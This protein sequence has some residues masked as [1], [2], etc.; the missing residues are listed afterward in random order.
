MIFGRRRLDQ[1][2]PFTRFQGCR[3][4]GLGRGNLLSGGIG[5]MVEHDVEV[6]GAIKLRANRMP[7]VI[8][9]VPDNAGFIDAN[10]RNSI[11]C[12][13]MRDLVEIMSQGLV[14][15]DKD[16]L[17]I[18]FGSVHASCPNIAV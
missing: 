4:H 8:G 2:Y 9:F 12:Q 1:L 13:D 5:N 14:N 17:V 10:F 16:F 15:P 3:E 11:L 7:L 18:I 6:L